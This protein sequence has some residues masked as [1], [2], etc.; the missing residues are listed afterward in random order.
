MHICS[1]YYNMRVM[2]TLHGI[3]VLQTAVLKKLAKR[4]KR[5][6][7]KKSKYSRMYI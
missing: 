2:K 7:K 4:M 3:P 1:I 6:I 5:P